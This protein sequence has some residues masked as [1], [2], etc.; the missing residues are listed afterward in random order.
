MRTPIQ[1]RQN[2]LYPLDRNT[3]LYNYIRSLNPV[4]YYPLNEEQGNLALNHA[5]TTLG[6]LNGTIAGATIGKQ[7]LIGKSYSFDGA[8][9]DISRDLQNF[10][11]EYS[12]LWIGYRAI[13]TTTHMIFGAQSGSN[14]KFGYANGDNL[15]IRAYTGGSTSTV[16]AISKEVWNLVVV[17]RNSNNKVDAFINNNSP[18]RLF[19]DV[20]QIGTF[21]FSR[22]GS[23]EGNFFNGFL[24]H[25]TIFNRAINTSEIQKIA[26]IM[27]I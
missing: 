27:R 26:R 8:N 22:I 3:Q 5:P 2:L 11:G 7:G 25:A 12:F 16:V 14:S 21:N 19:S 18:Q 15:F 17:T 9:D 6:T 24:Q 13:N 23:A 20:A 1:R 4:A 10:T